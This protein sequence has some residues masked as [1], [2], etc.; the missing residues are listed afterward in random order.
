MLFFK[1][2]SIKRGFKLTSNI[3]IACSFATSV[4]LFLHSLSSDKE[5]EQLERDATAFEEDILNTLTNEGLLVEQNV[6]IGGYKMTFAI[7]NRETNKYML[8]IE[9]DHN[10]LSNKNTRDRD[11]HRE[12][13]LNARG[14]D[15]YRIWSNRWFHSKEKVLQEIKDMLK[16]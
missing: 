13:Y 3:L 7:K 6:G 2:A 5:D 11:I 15:V 1:G 8:G 14:W 16:Y 4:K 12:K 9:C 10:L